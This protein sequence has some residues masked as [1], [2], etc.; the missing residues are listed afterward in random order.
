MVTPG[1][2]LRPG[3]RSIRLYHPDI[4]HDRA[5]HW[6]GSH[7]AISGLQ[8]RVHE[9]RT[10]EAVDQDSLSWCHEQ[11]R[12]LVPEQDMEVP[13]TPPS[14]E[15][16]LSFYHAEAALLRNPPHCTCETGSFQG[17]STPLTD[18]YISQIRPSGLF[19]VRIIFWNCESF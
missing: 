12:K 9:N 8:D 10:H 2:S 5:K 3:S 6:S 1:V 15:K 13:I 16:L 19:R 18:L 14:N 4:S 17:Q 7:Y 11:G